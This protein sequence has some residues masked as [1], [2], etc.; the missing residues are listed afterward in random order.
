MLTM[1]IVHFN[2]LISK[3]L[4]N[5]LRNF[6][7]NFPSVDRAYV[8]VYL[9]FF[10]VVDLNDLNDSRISGFGNFDWEDFEFQAFQ[11]QE[12]VQVS[13]KRSSQKLPVRSLIFSA[14]RDLIRSI[15]K[16]KNLKTSL[17]IHKL[18]INVILGI[19]K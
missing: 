7:Q 10:V 15:Q 8:F 14:T 4:L 3:I 12:S 11:G 17:L 2:C 13:F 16:G 6:F 9:F 19:I 5:F 18:L 1:Y